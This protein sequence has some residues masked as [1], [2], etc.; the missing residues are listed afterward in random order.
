MDDWSAVKPFVAVTAV[1]EVTFVV[2]FGHIDA[3][4]KGSHT[5][6]QIL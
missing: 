5:P 3:E 6:K 2:V 4:I 1:H